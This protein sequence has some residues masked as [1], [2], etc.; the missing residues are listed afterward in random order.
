[1]KFTHLFLH[2]IQIREKFFFFLTFDAVPH[3]AQCRCTRSLRCKTYYG[4][5]LADKV[6]TPYSGDL[7]A[8][9]FKAQ[10]LSLLINW[11]GLAIMVEFNNDNRFI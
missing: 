7:I 1:M 10:V 6:R 8:T 2:F 5:M 9:L 11:P 3:A 4:M